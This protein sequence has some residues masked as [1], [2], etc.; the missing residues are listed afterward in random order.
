[1]TGALLRLMDYEKNT[2]AE[3][4]SAVECFSSYKISGAAFYKRF[5]ERTAAAVYNVFK[6]LLEYYNTFENG[7]IYEKLFG[8]RLHEPHFIFDKPF[9]MKKRRT[10]IAFT[11]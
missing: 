8:K 4:L 6:M 10:P 7:N 9:F 1:M 11:K 2:P 5:P 3:A